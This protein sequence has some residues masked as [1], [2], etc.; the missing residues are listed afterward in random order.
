MNVLVT[1]ANGFIGRS[2]CDYLLQKGYQV[3]ATMRKPNPHHACCDQAIVEDIDANTAWQKALEDIDVV[4][5]LAARAH[6]LNESTTNPLAEFR[7]VNVD[8]T[9]NLARQAAKS[10]VKRFIFFSSIGVLGAET[11]LNPFSETSEPKPHSDYAISKLEAEEV[12]KKICSETGMEFVIIRPP[13]VYGASA[14]GNF[15][16]LLKLVNLNLPLPLGSVKNQRSMVSLENLVDFTNVCLV[17]SNAINQT[18]LVADGSDV[19]TPQ[20]IRLLGEGME[21]SVSLLPVPVK[22]LEFGALITGKKN[23]LQQLCHSL[24][25][26]ISK[27]RNTLDW[28]PP[29]LVAD[30]LRRAAQQYLDNMH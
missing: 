5:H 29:V 26:D 22:L 27:A 4:I 18:F 24:Q 19:S 17:H 16:R 11:L 21:K 3:R 20:L 9:L 6:V 13:L 1:G 2:L 23:M 15:A 7:K 30:G 8:G 25:I 12:L 28:T 14:P 10:G